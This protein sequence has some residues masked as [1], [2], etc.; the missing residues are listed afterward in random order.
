MN[1]TRLLVICKQPTLTA[2]SLSLGILI[3]SHNLGKLVLP[4]FHQKID[5]GTKGDNMLDLVYG[6]IQ[7]RTIGI[8][9]HTSHPSQQTHQQTDQTSLERG[10]NIARGGHT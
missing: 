4:K 10:E 6:N 7:E 3:T 2:S 8:H 1:S 9:L 5:F